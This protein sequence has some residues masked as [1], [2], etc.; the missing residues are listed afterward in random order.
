MLLL[1]CFTD[2]AARVQCIPRCPCSNYTP[3]FEPFSDQPLIGLKSH[4]SV[5]FP[6]LTLD[7]G[8]ARTPPHSSGGSWLYALFRQ[9]L[10][11]RRFWRSD[12][13]FSPYGTHGAGAQPASQPGQT[14]GVFSCAHFECIFSDFPISFWVAWFHWHHTQLLSSSDCQLSGLLFSTTLWHVH[15]STVWCKQSSATWQ[16]PRVGCWWS[17]RLTSTLDFPLL[18]LLVHFSSFL[19]LFLFV[20]S[21][22]CL[23]TWLWNVFL[24]VCILCYLCSDVCLYFIL[25][26]GFLDIANEST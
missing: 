9:E 14:T 16:G 1:V 24:E 20:W 25:H 21:F 15:R 10:G 26:S 12:S 23:V 8:M 13:V 6:P 18:H 5:R 22:D 7:L 19:G 2:L 11:N 17:V 3:G 4:E